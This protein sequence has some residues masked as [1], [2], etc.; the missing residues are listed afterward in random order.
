MLTHLEYIF[1]RRYFVDFFDYY[2]E[3]TGKKKIEEEDNNS[4]FL[5]T[6]GDKLMNHEE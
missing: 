4:N 3:K 6:Q 2:K 1:A 5:D